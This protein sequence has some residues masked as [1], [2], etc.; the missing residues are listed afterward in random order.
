[1]DVEVEKWESICVFWK[2]TNDKRSVGRGNIASR[3]CKILGTAGV[4]RS[5]NLSRGMVRGLIWHLTGWVVECSG[6]NLGPSKPIVSS[7]NER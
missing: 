2:R 1:M 4:D 6:S 3:S 7:F 5:Q